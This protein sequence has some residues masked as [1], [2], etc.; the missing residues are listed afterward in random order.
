MIQGLSNLGGLLICIY[1]IKY[2]AVPEGDCWEAG[3]MKNENLFSSK[4]G[5]SGTSCQL[6]RAWWP[7]ANP[8]V[9]GQ[10]ILL[11]AN[12]QGQL[13]EHVAGAVT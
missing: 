9:L 6:L 7:S 1:M 10:S 4:W 12:E 8:H 3:L 5:G 13:P 2:A 11:Q